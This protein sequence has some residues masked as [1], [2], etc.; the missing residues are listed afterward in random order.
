MHRLRRIFR[1]DL[2]R[3]RPLW[4]IGADEGAGRSSWWSA[5][6]P[7]RRIL[8]P[9]DPPLRIDTRAR[10]PIPNEFRRERAQIALQA[11][12]QLFKSEFPEALLR[13]ST[14]IYNCV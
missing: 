13:S 12:V 4:S 8:L 7:R 1:M 10:W 11:S 5:Q 3:E 6:R 2:A 9:G 14:S